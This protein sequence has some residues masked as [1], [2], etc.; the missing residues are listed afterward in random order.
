MISNACQHISNVFAQTTLLMCTWVNKNS[1]KSKKLK[2]YRP[3][4]YVDGTREEMVIDTAA[5]YVRLKFRLLEN[6]KLGQWYISSYAGCADDLYA[7]LLV[8]I[9]SGLFRTGIRVKGPFPLKILVLLLA[10]GGMIGIFLLIISF[11]G[12]NKGYCSRHLALTVCS[13]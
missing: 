11:L 8:E 2:E 6:A 1:F 3:G 13:P 4:R 12:Q 7:K 9:K 5:S 10:I